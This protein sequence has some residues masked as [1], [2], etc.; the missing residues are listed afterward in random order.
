MLLPRPRDGVT[1]SRDQSDV[2]LID[3]ER[4]EVYQLNETA[5]RIFAYCQAQLTL[6]AAVAEL[7]AGL[8][9]PDQEALVRSDVCAVIDQ[10]HEL[11]VC[12]PLPT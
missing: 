11:G 9:E 4:G 5:A 3:E 1:I 12:E 7:L 6:D 8:S 10:L 2:F